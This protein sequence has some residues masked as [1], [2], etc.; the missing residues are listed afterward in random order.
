M[1]LYIPPSYQLAERDIVIVG[2]GIAGL[3]CAITLKELGFNP[4]VIT[5]GKGNTY[6]SQ[7][8]IAAAIAPD[9]SPY[10]HYLDTLRAGKLINDQEAVLI[11]TYSGPQ[12]IA[13]LTRWGVNFDKNDHFYELTLEAAHSKRRILKVKDYTG[14]AIYEAL[15]QRAKTLNIEFL[16]GELREIF[17]YDGKVSGLL[18]KR[19]S[20]YLVIRTKILVLAT[21]GAASLYARHS[22][23]QKIGGDA[24]GIALRAG[25]VVRET[26]FVQF[27]PTVLRNT[28]Y[29]ISEAVRGEGAYLI[30]SEGRRFVNELAPRDEVSKA[31]FRELSAGREV[32][33]DFSPLVKKGIKIE[34]RFPQ[35]YEILRSVNL[36][37]YTDLIPVEPAAH[38]FIGGIATDTFGRT[39]VENLYAVGECACTGLHGANRLASNSLLEGAVFGI[40]AAHDIAVKLPFL[41]FAPLTL[42]PT[43][44]MTLKKDPPKGIVEQLQNLM[45]EKV[46]LIRTEKGLKAALYQINLWLEEIYPFT[47]LGSEYSKI[48]DLLLVAK[49]ITLNALKRKE[50][51]GCHHREDYPTE[52]ESY[53]KVHLSLDLNDLWSYKNLS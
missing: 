29:L 27:H 12:V 1:N 38:Y 41:K 39:S 26:E 30:N 13:T 17:T 49:S 53:R 11:T 52:R 32:Y 34:E 6:L 7:G 18:L 50:T 9:D 24:I 4:L 43:E 35:I 51:R 48:F 40:R 10:L 37:P 20:D 44:G 19:E 2:D 46:G 22:N 47:S 5:R 16:Q 15:H 36:N 14:K 23:I 25:A 45:W 8:G 21:G 3:S 33:L 31:I 28:N 42:K